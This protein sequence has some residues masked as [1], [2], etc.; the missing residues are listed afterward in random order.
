MDQQ[1]QL[2]LQR[3]DDLT[4]EFRELRDGVQK[5]VQ[6]ATADPEM[7]LTRVRKVL[8]Y[9]IRDVYT[10]RYG[11]EP[12]T[13]PL[14]NLLQLLVKD[15]HLPTRIDAYANTIRK[16][17]N[18]G[19]HSFGE[20]IT[21][22]DVQA[23]LNQ[24]LPILLWY[25]EVE[26]PE[27]M[28]KT[29]APDE[30]ARREQ[31]EQERLRVEAER[32]R[33]EAEQSRRLAEEETRRRD[34]ETRRKQL[35]VEAL[36]RAAEVNAAGDGTKERTAEESERRPA[37]ARQP[38]N[39]TN[40]LGMEFVWIPPG[41]FIMGMDNGNL[42]ERPAHQ[43]TISAGFY[44]GKY[45]VTQEQWQSLMGNNPSHFKGKNLPV[46]GLTWDDAMAFIA[47]LNGQRDGYTYRLPTEA[48]WE[49]AA[50]AG[51]TGQYAGELD[52]IA[53][54]WKSPGGSTH[55]VGCKHPNAFGLFDMYG[56]VWEWCQ[57][58]YHDNYLGAPTDGSAWLSGGEQKYRVMRGGSW[59]HDASFC[60]STFRFKNSWISRHFLN[61]GLRVVA[62]VRTQ[63]PDA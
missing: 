61:V 16:L 29:L 40:R 32:V 43:V 28:K 4:G 36:R 52:A 54:Y 60:R 49:Y 34:E 63:P 17:G 56:N 59:K 44:M 20:E 57:D 22:E 8:E 13:Q 39:M 51:T 42:N 58:W 24:L 11:R 50:R 14:E 5:V 31:E 41:S 6:I 21:T 9:L 38:V 55:P 3:L 45:E 15:G 7:A 48:V 35:E 23:S 10:R 1:I 26:R 2:L 27:V 18:V 25:F 37:A 19:T 46:E 33:A 62:V 47:R 53:W 30:Q 12:K